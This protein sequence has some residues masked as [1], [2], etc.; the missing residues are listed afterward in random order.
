MSDAVVTVGRPWPSGPIL[1]LTS[2]IGG[3]PVGLPEN[4]WPS[5]R[6]CGRHLD[7]LLQLNLQDPVPISRRF[8]F[9]YVFMCSGYSDRSGRNQCNTWHPEAGA[10]R[11]TL[12]E[13]PDPNIVPRYL[14]VTKWPDFDLT[15]GPPWSRDEGRVPMEA[16]MP[17]GSEGVDVHLETLIV[18][19]RTRAERS[20]PQKSRLEIVERRRKRWRVRLEVPYRPPQ[21]IQ[22]GGKPIWIQGD[23]TPR[24]PQCGGAMKLLAQILADLEDTF[25]KENPAWL[26]F[27][28]GGVAYAFICEG[29]C[30]PDGTY[31]MWQTT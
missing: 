15:F 18:M 1:S 28:A 8:L 4:Q 31:L 29:E 22:L 27:G 24:C 14:G 19:P 7:F 30:S 23:E 3:V 6:Q 21:T 20:V 11:I 13:S 26:P 12:L 10:S 16:L 25:Q 17:T 5:C 9:A 2:K